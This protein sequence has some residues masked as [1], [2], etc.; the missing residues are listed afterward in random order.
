RNVPKL[1]PGAPKPVVKISVI[2]P[3]RNEE[4]NLSRLLPSLR[5]QV[6]APHEIIVV[7]DQS[8][9]RTGE[10]AREN[11]AVVVGGRDLPEGWYGKPWACQQG[12]DA[13][14]GDWFLFLDADTVLEGEGLLRIGHLATDE[15]V[16][17]SVCPYH[18]VSKAY[19]Q[20]SSF[21]NVIMILGMNAFTTKGSEADE[22]GL[23]GQAM[24][25]SRST[26]E[27][28]GGHEKVKDQVLENFHLSRFL[29]EAGHQ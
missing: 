27:G 10:V 8:E 4:K 5:N 26:Y 22:I 19:E 3:A 24:L 18:R 23:F 28:M 9:D 11:G 12:A 7:N 25:I 2:I 16:V 1:E 14:T 13:S 29:D 20:L 17:H 6:H 21:F 15:T